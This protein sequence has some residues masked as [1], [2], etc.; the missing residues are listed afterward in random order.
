MGKAFLSCLLLTWYFLYCV[1]EVVVYPFILAMEVCFFM[2]LV[3]V[4]KHGFSLLKKA[5]CNVVSVL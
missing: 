3:Q 5:H 1:V 2:L 4:T